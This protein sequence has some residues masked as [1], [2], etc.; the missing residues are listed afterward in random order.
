MYSG[1]LLN[2]NFS[3]PT[4]DYKNGILENSYTDACKYG[5]FFNKI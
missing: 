4:Y 2:K 5:G 3:T 1:T